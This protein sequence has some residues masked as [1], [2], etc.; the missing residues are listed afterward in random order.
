MNGVL[1][2][3]AEGDELIDVLRELFFKYSKCVRMYRNIY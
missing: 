2:H 1:F 3:Y